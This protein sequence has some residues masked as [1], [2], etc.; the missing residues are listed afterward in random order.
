MNNNKDVINEIKLTV[1]KK[2]EFENP[3]IQNINSIIA[4]CYRDCHDNYYHTFKYEGIYNLNFANVIDNEIVNLTI[5]DTSSN[6]RE[7]KKKIKNSRQNNFKF[8][9]IN[10]FKIEIYSNISYMNIDYRLGLSKILPL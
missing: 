3:I 1:V 6:T 4:K 2:Y 5:S 8:I 10:N 9:R 7:L